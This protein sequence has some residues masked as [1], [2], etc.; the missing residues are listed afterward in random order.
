[1]TIDKKI[2]IAIILIF[3]IIVFNIIVYG[4]II[5]EL[6]SAK[7]DIKVYIGI[8]IIPI[9]LLINYFILFKPFINLLKS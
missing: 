4:I 5:P 8:I 3:T 7:S 2:I 1:M 9:N 6:L